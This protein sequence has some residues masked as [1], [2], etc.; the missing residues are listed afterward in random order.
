MQTSGE[1]RQ[2]DIV[3]NKDILW[4]ANNIIKII[5]DSFEVLSEQM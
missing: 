3:L 1:Q 2:S 4:N 5:K